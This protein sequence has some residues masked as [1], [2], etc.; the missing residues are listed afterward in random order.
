MNLTTP[1]RRPSRLALAVL[2]AALAGG[3][4]LTARAVD[5]SAADASAAPPAHAPHGHPGHGGPFMAMGLPRGPMLDHLL[6]R[7]D[8][9]PA[10]RDQVHRIADAQAAVMRAEMPAMRADHEQM[11]QILSAPAIDA[12][13][14]EAVRQRMAQRHDLASRQA[15][16]ALI[17]VAQVLTPEQ[18]VQLQSLMHEGHG[19]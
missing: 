10:Q 16:Q 17:Q 9:T 13:A 14:A 11:A 7:V 15:L 5:A 12:S 18:R 1:S 2:G 6:D 3:V 19:R 8:A 4:A